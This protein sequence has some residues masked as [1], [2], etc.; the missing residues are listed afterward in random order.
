MISIPMAGACCCK[1]RAISSKTPTPLAP[2]FA[3]S[4][5]YGDEYQLQYV[6]PEE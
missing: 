5:G 4:K 3:P 1:W 6:L 2:S